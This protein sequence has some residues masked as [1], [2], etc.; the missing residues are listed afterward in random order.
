MA[1]KQVYTASP[2]DLVRPYDTTAWEDPDHGNMGHADGP[3]LL[4]RNP[5]QETKYAI[6]FLSY[7]QDV[8]LD[9]SECT[10]IPIP[11][12]TIVTVVKANAATPDDPG[13]RGLLS[14]VR[15][16]LGRKAPVSMLKG[17]DI[18]YYFTQEGQDAWDEYVGRETGYRVGQS[19]SDRLRDPI[20]GQLKEDLLL[21][22]QPRSRA[23]II[24]RVG[25]DR[26]HEYVAKGYWTTD[27]D[28]AINAPE[29]EEV[30]IPDVPEGEAPVF[31]TDIY[32][33]RID[34]PEEPTT[35]IESERFKRAWSV[36]NPED[37]SILGEGVEERIFSAKEKLSRIGPRQVGSGLLKGARGAG[38]LGGA[39][40]EAE[41]AGLGGIVRT[42]AKTVKGA[43]VGTAAEIGKETSKYGGRQIKRL[44]QYGSSLLLS[45]LRSSETGKMM[46]LSRVPVGQNVMFVADEG[47]HGIERGDRGQVRMGARGKDKVVY[48]PDTGE[49]VYPSQWT[50]VS[51]VGMVQSPETGTLN[52]GLGRYGERI[53]VGRYPGSGYMGSRIPFE[54]GSQSAGYDTRIELPSGHSMS[55]R[56]WS[57]LSND[58]KIKLGGGIG[59][60]GGNKASKV[61]KEFLARYFP[62]LLTEEDRYNEMHFGTPELDILKHQLQRSQAK[63]FGT[64]EQAGVLTGVKTRG[65]VTASI[66]TDSEDGTPY[67][68]VIM[69]WERLKTTGQSDRTRAKGTIIEGSKQLG[70]LEPAESK[71]IAKLEMQIQNEYGVDEEE[72]R[73]V[74]KSSGEDL[75][76]MDEDLK[77]MKLLEAGGFG[78]GR[79]TQQRR[80][81]M[82]EVVEASQPKQSEQ[83]DPRP[84]STTFYGSS[85]SPLKDLDLGSMSL[86]ES[87]YA[88]PPEQE[89]QTVSAPS[90]Y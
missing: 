49:I 66:K 67:V 64:K 77:L 5:T 3:G 62:M 84:T 73:T 79:V 22:S 15:G 63:V 56:A 34:K 72:V 26:F 8:E 60:V 32:G 37:P 48:I 59:I 13:A 80:P 25:E 47:V 14:K 1:T 21:M 28:K 27:R 10:W 83:P 40:V 4:K 90:F 42:G 58:M 19:A 74:W 43:P 78:S 6:C 2:G 86:E 88:D 50:V 71:L 55:P 44:G 81:S 87:F 82:S 7:E 29:E 69:P 39:I 20:K 53:G 35:G 36:L 16:F 18:I 75:D 70:L 52:I 24:D 65:K 57:E 89:E 11:N 38:E 46:R 30:D 33:L 76:Q 12:N 51:L 17:S 23:E 41:L 54:A 9:Q 68:S 61:R 85:F 45:T 31:E